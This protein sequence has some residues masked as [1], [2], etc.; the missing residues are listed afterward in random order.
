MEE[1]VGYGYV[2]CVDVAGGGVYHGGG[3]VCY[4]QEYCGRVSDGGGGEAV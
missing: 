4:G 2:E 1:A 3:D